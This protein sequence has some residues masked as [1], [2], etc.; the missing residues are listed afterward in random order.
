MGK[1][2]RERCFIEIP[3]RYPLSHL[4]RPKA[5]YEVFN[6]NIGL[7]SHSGPN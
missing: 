3:A 5:A 7:H 1:M 4:S 6:R 2:E